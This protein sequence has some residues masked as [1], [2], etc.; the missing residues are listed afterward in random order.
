MHA[1]RDSDCFVYLTKSTT[2]A[3]EYTPIPC[4]ELLY[5]VG[6][7]PLY[8]VP[9]MATEPSSATS[10]GLFGR[11]AK[12]ALSARRQGAPRI[13]VFLSLARG[14]GVLRRLLYC[15]R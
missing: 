11:V 5:P 15:S 6:S 8:V 10:G 4:C 13:L 7:L 1:R 2:A 9:S 14:D 12:C 3:N